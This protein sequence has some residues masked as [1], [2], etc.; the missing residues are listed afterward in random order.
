MI[1]NRS[2]HPDKL[3][4]YLQLHARPEIQ[5]SAVVSFPS[6]QNAIGTVVGIL[7][8]AIPIARVEFL[9]KI[10]M[11]MCNVYSKTDYDENP[12]CFLEF[13]GSA[14]S[15]QEQIE[16]VKEIAIEN[17]GFITWNLLKLDPLQNILY[18]VNKRKLSST[19]SKK[20][21]RFTY[22]S[23]PTRTFRMFKILDL[24]NSKPN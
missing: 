19:L 24:F 1:L 7:Q 2:N 14:A 9:D 23:N 20:I 3:F 6:V 8:S 18:L 5:S 17:K 10:S 21:R 15:V 4:F 13:H 12:T 16:L 11:K 22:L